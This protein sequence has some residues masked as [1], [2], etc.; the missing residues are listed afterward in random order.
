MSEQDNDRRWKDSDRGVYEVWY[1]TWND[2]STGDGF[3]LRYI[4]EAPQTGL[5]IE[6]QQPRGELWF[7]R[8]SSR[9]PKRT[10]GIRR[11]V[12]L[13]QVASSESPFS[14]SIA[15]SR[16]THASATGQ[17][18]GN[19]HDVRWDLRWE[20]ATQT[21][22][23][24]PDVM[25]ARGGL[26]ETTVHS[27]NPRVPM[28]GTLVVDGETYAFEGA[29]F[30]QSHVWG[31]KHAYTWTWGR[32]A[33]FAGTDALLEVMG[34][35]LM[36]RGILTPRLSLAVLHLDGETYRLNQYRHILR[37]RCSWTTGR[38][39]FTAWSKAVKLEGQL[40]CAPSQ[41]INAEYLDPDGTQ[42]WCANTEI[43]D[44]RVTV[45]RR[46][47]LA[48]REHRVLTSDGRAHFEHGGR[49]RDPS[50]THLHELVR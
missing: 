3:W 29:S 7:T 13:T 46:S 6:H 22:R 42:V 11:H 30:G 47:G 23:L 19:G 1:M 21:M 17:L 43:G 18:A 48:W 27:P 32:C 40:T 41:M 44:A 28:S 35:R 24:L 14:V 37:N 16:L 15:Q 26:G 9:D 2:S 50:V 4:T 8:F 45:Y 49:T 10:F 34:T 12:A 38:Y 31:K 20:P 33:D 5:S 39:E 25:Y 36:R